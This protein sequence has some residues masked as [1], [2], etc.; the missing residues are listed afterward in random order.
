M[1]LDLGLDGRLDHVRF[2]TRLFLSFTKLR[3][4]FKKKESFYVQ[5]SFLGKVIIEKLLWQCRKKKVNE[6]ILNK[7]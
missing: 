1:I 2:V 6:K 3:K 7:L 5:S 4:Y